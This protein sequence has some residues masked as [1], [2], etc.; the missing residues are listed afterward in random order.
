MKMRP[1]ALPLLVAIILA[2]TGCVST[3]DLSARLVGTWEATERSGSGEK[4]MLEITYGPDGTL[5]GWFWNHEHL[6]DGTEKDVKVTVQGR[7]SISDGKI[8]VSN[9]VT[10]PAG[11]LP[12]DYR[13]VEIVSLKPEGILLRSL[14]DGSLV[15]RRKKM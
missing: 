5:S 3:T 4:V 12:K 2:I 10:E 1:L 15:Y 8:A 13:S 11:R 14:E 7:W 6:P 9:C